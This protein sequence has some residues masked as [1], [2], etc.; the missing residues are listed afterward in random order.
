MLSRENR[1]RGFRSLRYVQK[2]GNQIRG[3]LAAVRYVLNDRRT[4]YR[5]TVT[6]SRK[7]SKSA[8]VRN[9]IRRRVYEVL[10]SL[11]QNMNEPYDIVVTIFSEQM[12]TMP[13]ADL[14]LAVKSLLKQAKIIKTPNKT[15][16]D[17]VN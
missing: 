2:K 11:S 17:K 8:V 16:H 1:F 3:Q 6:V 13:Q 12:A 9:R 4:Q 14:E 5:A 7:V 15:G 10:R